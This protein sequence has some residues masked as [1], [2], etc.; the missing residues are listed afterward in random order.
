MLFKRKPRE[1]AASEKK[2]PDERAAA[3]AARPEQALRDELGFHR[4]WYLE[5]RLSEEMARASRAEG[6]FSICGWRLRLLPGESL[7]PELMVRAADLIVKSLRT[8]D[9]VARIDEE[10]IAA[11][12][13]DAEFQNASTVAYR[14]KADLQTRFPSAGRWQAGVA[15][16]NR[17]GVDADGLIQVMF[18]RLEEDARAA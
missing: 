7:A 10:R 8:Y 1:E 17:D 16:F 18:R 5:L 14:I 2:P 9:L 4:L 3:G 13:L 15:T 6:L 12:L 11:V